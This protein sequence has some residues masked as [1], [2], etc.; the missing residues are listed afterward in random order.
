M[1][2]NLHVRLSSSNMEE[3]LW[4]FAGD[5]AKCLLKID[6][7]LNLLISHNTLQSHAVPSGFCFVDSTFAFFLNRPWRFTHHQAMYGLFFFV[8]L[9]GLVEEALCHETWPQQSLDLDPDRRLWMSWSAGW[10]ENSPRV[11][12]I[13]GESL[14]SAEHSW[15]LPHE[16][17]WDDKNTVR[18]WP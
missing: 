14:K 16:T 5:F 11:F 18:G 7:T 15:W 17:D 9:L 3:V 12:T 6:G 10:R 8:F 13:Y 2:G 4:W 1:C